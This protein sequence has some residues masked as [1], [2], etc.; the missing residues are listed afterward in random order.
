M[1]LSVLIRIRQYPLVPA[2]APATRMQVQVSKVLLAEA[3]GVLVQG[4]E[5]GVGKRVPQVRQTQWAHT[6]ITLVVI[7]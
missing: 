3:E 1:S 6:K 5:E 2:V 7:W 4:G